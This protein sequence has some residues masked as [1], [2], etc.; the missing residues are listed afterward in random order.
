MSN[1][2]SVEFI[3]CVNTTKYEVYKGYTEWDLYI[4]DVWFC[5]G[6]YRRIMQV[7]LNKIGSGYLT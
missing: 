1:D 6:E 5:G 4:D 7:F 2:N 3:V